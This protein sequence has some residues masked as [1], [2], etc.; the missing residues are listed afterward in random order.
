MEKNKE[1]KADDWGWWWEEKKEK[2]IVYFGLWEKFSIFSF[3]IYQGVVPFSRDIELFHLVKA[4]LKP[5]AA[6]PK[7]GRPAN[8]SGA[9]KRSKNGWTPLKTFRSSSA[10]LSLFAFQ[11]F[12]L[13]IFL[14]KPWAKPVGFFYQAFSNCSFSTHL[15]RLGVWAKSSDFTPPVRQ[16]FGGFYIDWPFRFYPTI[17]R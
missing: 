1:R 5:S 17:S 13:L 11:F 10:F 9:N 16:E 8:T 14:P 15:L 7:R 12:L 6:T 4:P 3:V 2:E